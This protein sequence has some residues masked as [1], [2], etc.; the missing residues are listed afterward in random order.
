[1]FFSAFWLLQ[2]CVTPVAPPAA[3]DPTIEVLP[4]TDPTP[5]PTEDHSQELLDALG[6]SVWY[7]VATRDGVSRTVE[8]H[9]RASQGE[10]VEVINPWGP[11]T[12]RQLRRMEVD[13]DGS[14]VTTTVLVPAGWPEDPA[15]GT[16]QTGTITL[17]EGTPRQIRIES[18]SR[19]EVFQAGVAAQPTTGFTATARVW[20]PGDPV[21]EAFCDSG[22]FGFDYET[23]FDFARGVGLAPQAK[24]VVAGVPIGTWQ[25]QGN[26]EFS[27]SDV[28]GFDRDGGTDLTDRFN[29]IVTYRAIVQHPGGTLAFRETD[30]AVEDGLW[31]FLGDAAGVGGEEDYFFE[32]HG[33]Y[34]WDGTEGEPSIDLPPGPIA[35]EV[36]IA[37]CTEPIE[38]VSLEFSTAGGP[39][40]PASQ[41]EAMPIL[42]SEDFAAPF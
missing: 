7:G 25:D 26:N 5:D 18:G 8:Q 34:W 13:P 9:F 22:V 24:D 42:S 31:V 3:P 32:V 1:M 41:L 39:W 19:V 14:T 12:S 4:P 38:T 17:L 36:M 28:P 33:F 2:A 37:R 10:W 11:A 30:D 16:Q 21:D 40:L 35:V 20:G 6:D 27:V 15:E 23:L 29:F